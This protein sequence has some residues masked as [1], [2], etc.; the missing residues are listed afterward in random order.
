[1]TAIDVRG[2]SKTMSGF[3][4][5][6]VSFSVPRGYITGLI[7][8]NGAGKSTLIKMLMGMVVPDQ[9]SISIHGEPAGIAGAAYK[10][11][12]GY[13]SDENIYYDTLTLGKM[14]EIFKS[15]YPRWDEGLFKEYLDRFELPVKKKIKDC[16]KG[17]KTKFALALALSHHPDLL[18]MDEPTAGLDPVFRRELLELLAEFI[19]DERRTVLFSTHL[20]TDLDKVADYITFIHRGRLVFSETKDEVLERHLIVKG[21][22]EL[23]DADTRKEFIGLRETDYGFEGLAADGSRLQSIFGSSALYHQPTLE[24]IMYYTAKGGKAYA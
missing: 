22:K 7:G 14:K 17:M 4:L 16:S 8:P 9:G 15:F 12:I 10:A 3:T 19:Q 11:N 18:I 23:L 24:D 21:S 20:T 1:M 13:V 5:E 2:L 6:Q